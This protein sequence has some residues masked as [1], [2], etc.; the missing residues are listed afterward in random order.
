MVMGFDTM[1]VLDNQGTDF[2]VDKAQESC[3]VDY[4]CL[5]KGGG[6]SF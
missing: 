2:G 6:Q 1:V 5:K 4:G 3:L